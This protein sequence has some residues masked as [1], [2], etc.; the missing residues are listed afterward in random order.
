MGN[1]ALS[2]LLILAGI[3]VLSI[4]AAA[5]AKTE[6]GTPGRDKL[7]GTKRADKLIGRAG[8]DKLIGRRGADK[9]IG[10]KGGDLLKGGRGN[11]LLRGGLAK[12]RLRGGGGDDE[13]ISGSGLG[14]LRGGRGDDLLLSSPKGGTMNGG[15]GS[16]QFNF[17]DGEPIG[18]DGD[19]L[20]QARDGS[21]DEINCG[22]GEDIAVVDG[23]EEGV[24]DCETLI[25]PNTTGSRR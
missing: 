24:L 17:L 10:G 15:P 5:I 21:E 4:A 16:D 18:G 14:N 25:E 1:R 3:G 13:L 2:P 23:S 19:D 8:P 9:L 22:P 12:D 20:I 11:D 6:R 7:L